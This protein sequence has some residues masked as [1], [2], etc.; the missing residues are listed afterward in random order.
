MRINAL[1]E[2]N[3]DFFV[4]IY[5]WIW[6]GRLCRCRIEPSKLYLPKLDGWDEA[7][8]FVYKHNLVS[9]SL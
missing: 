4:G 9:S 5:R 1:G 8:L 7:E 3:R 6:A 2:L